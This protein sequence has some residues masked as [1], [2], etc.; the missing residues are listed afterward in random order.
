M[1]VTVVGPLD[2]ETRCANG[3]YSMSNY[4]LLAKPRPDP[5]LTAAEAEASLGA[6]ITPILQ[7][8]S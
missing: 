8:G 3:L 2:S 5:K 6:S 7:R 1:T 4:M